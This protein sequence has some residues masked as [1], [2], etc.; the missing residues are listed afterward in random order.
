MIIVDQD[1]ISK[2]FQ[3]L[4]SATDLHDGYCIHLRINNVKSHLRQIVNVTQYYAP[5]AHIYCAEDES[6]FLTVNGISFTDCR[7]LMADINAMFDVK[8]GIPLDLY[9]LAVDTGTLLMLLKKD[10][11]ARQAAAMESKLRQVREQAALKR[12]KILNNLPA[13]SG[14]AIAAR[15]QGRRTPQIMII[16]DDE[17]SRRLVESTLQKQFPLVGLGSAEGALRTYADTAPD[18]LFLDIDLP[19]VSGHELL[20]RIVAFDPNAYIVMLSGNT[21][22]ANIL[23]AMQHGAKGFVGKPF[24]RAKLF[25]YIERCPAFSKE[26]HT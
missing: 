20:E 13:V 26:M 23:N 2:L 25:Q 15:R 9:D 7:R 4:R 6:G 5:S 1:A 19:D 14:D 22:K 12:E 24:T 3:R 18:L 17:F 21:D 10:I 8:G 11:D 16:E